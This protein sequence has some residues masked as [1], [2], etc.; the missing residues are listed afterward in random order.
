ML[1]RIEWCFGVVGVA[2][3]RYLGNHG[4]EQEDIDWQL[5]RGGKLAG[6]GGGAVGYARVHLQQQCAELETESWNDDGTLCTQ[7]HRQG[8]K[9]TLDRRT[10]RQTDRGS[11]SLS[12]TQGILTCNL[13]SVMECSSTVKSSY[14]L[15]TSPPIRTTGQ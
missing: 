5:G 11:I 2:R 13:G 1:L 6:G 9:V 15:P 14:Q 8:H 7:L 10:D 4:T 12:P 3:T